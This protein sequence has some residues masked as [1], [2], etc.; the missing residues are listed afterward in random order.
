M[1]QKEPVKERLL[2]G[3]SM[4][5]DARSLTAVK[6]PSYVLHE[7]QQMSNKLGIS[8]NAFVRMGLKGLLRDMKNKISQE[9]NNVR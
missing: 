2:D 8:F 9:E 7:A 1:S 5:E 6:L 4:H 3:R